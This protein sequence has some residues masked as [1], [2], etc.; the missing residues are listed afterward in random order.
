MPVEDSSV[1]EWIH[2]LKDGDQQAA[3][4][5]WQHFAER[6]Q[7]V[8]RSQLGQVPRR[9]ADEEDVVLSAFDGLCRGVQEG[10]FPNLHDRDDLWQILV[11]LTQRKAASQQR[12]VLSAKR[13][14]GKV[15]GDSLLAWSRP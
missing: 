6:L 9:A 7:E 11:M 14:G 4:Q 1:T 8:A 12:R 15:R 3:Q 2:A 5:L 10:R 13:G